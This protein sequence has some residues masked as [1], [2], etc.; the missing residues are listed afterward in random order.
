MEQLDWS[1]LYNRSKNAQTGGEPVPANTYQVVVAACEATLSKTGSKPQLKLRGKIQGGPYDGKTL[2]NTLTVSRES[3]TALNIFFRQL[4]AF[5]LDEAYLAT[6]PSLE[7]IAQVLVG[8][9]ASWVVS[10]G[11]YQGKARNSVD[12]IRPAGAAPQPQ[13]A[14]PAPPAPAPVAAPPA[15]APAPAPAPVAAPPVP[16]PAPAPPAPAPAPV[17]GPAPVPV[18]TAVPAAP[19]VAPF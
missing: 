1:D 15:P 10:V 9:P 6:N 11:E 3:D 12:D 19:P 18:T 4:A 7:T 13:A 5:G 2:Y 16:A 14:A 8:R 17:A